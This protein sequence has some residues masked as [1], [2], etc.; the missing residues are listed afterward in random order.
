MAPLTGSLA[1]LSAEENERRMLAGELYHAFTPRLTQERYRCR[2][3]LEKFNSL[4]DPSRRETVA[5]WREYTR[6]PVHT[7]HEEEESLQLPRSSHRIQHQ[8]VYETE[9]A[10]V[11]RLTKD[12][13][14]LP[15]QLADPQADEDQFHATD[16]WVENRVHCDYGFNIHIAPG[17]YCNMDCTYTMPIRIG[18]RTLIGPSCHF[19]SGTHPLDPAIRN[20]IQGPESGAPIA[21][22]E[23][24]WICGNVTDVPPFTL[25]AGNPARVIRKIESE[26]DPESAAY[27][28][29]GEPVM[30]PED[31]MAKVAEKEEV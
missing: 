13:R 4:K 8:A 2:R 17:A 23:D 27:K 24:C 31:A 28:K 21:I 14:P 3:A 19:Y 18:A 26:W 5:A 11:V 15:P 9:K 30:G 16:A 29:T 7:S 12:E 10:N 22:G 20:G 6:S 1:H 25:V